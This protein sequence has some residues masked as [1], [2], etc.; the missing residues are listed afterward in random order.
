ML[1]RAGAADLPAGPVTV[2]GDTVRHG[3]FAAT[4]AVAC[5]KGPV[6]DRAIGIADLALTLFDAVRPVAVIGGLVGFGHPALALMLAGR[7][8]ANI[9]RPVRIARGGLSGHRAIGPVAVIGAAIGKGDLAVARWLAL[10]ETAD[11]DRA[12]GVM[13]RP[14]ALDL[15][16]HPVAGIFK[17]VGQ[18]VGAGAVLP[19]GLEGALIDRAV[20]I[21]LGHH[22]LRHRTRGE[23]PG[24]QHGQRHIRNPAA[25]SHVGLLTP[26]PAKPYRPA[27]DLTSR[28]GRARAFPCRTTC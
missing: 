25:Q 13:R 8:R 14:L 6:I 4:C 9:D 18:F 7:K 15:A 20:V 12:I 22:L 23:R 3:Q 2:I 5:H 19:P 1:Q 16:R 10:G 26:T 11:I 28:A 21:L 27:P 24:D 17:P